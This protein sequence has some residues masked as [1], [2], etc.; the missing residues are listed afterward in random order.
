MATTKYLWDDETDTVVMETDGSGTTQAVYNSD[1]VRYGRLLSMRR[2]GKTYNYR[3]DVPG[4]TRALTDGT[5]QNTDTYSYDAWGNDRATTGATP[6]PYRYNG[7]YGY[8]YTA[9]SDDY[10]IRHRVYEPQIGRWE[11]PGL[12]STSDARLLN[13]PRESYGHYALNAV[14]SDPRSQAV[15]P[16]AAARRPVPQYHQELKRYSHFPCGKYFSEWHFT[17]P[18]APGRTL[19]ISQLCYSCMI[20]D[21][22]RPMKKKTKKTDCCTVVSRRKALSNCFYEVVEN[23]FG[24]GY[25]DINK[26]D[27]VSKVISGKCCTD[28][29]YIWVA[30]NVRLF[31]GALVKQRRDEKQA[32]ERTKRAADTKKWIDGIDDDF[33]FTRCGATVKTAGGRVEQPPF[34][35]DTSLMVAATYRTFRVSW[36]CCTNPATQSF[37][38]WPDNKQMIWKKRSR[39]PSLI[40]VKCRNT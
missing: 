26:N 40:S 11:S 2:G 28:K 29:G 13:A 7:Q 39:F 27:A 9:K 21:C 25:I 24:G 10:Y 3:Y 12:I 36:N 16:A 15:A 5:G 38:A 18:K 37:E 4:N 23:K 19:F 20:F 14:T 34:W 1:P 8:Q 33:K 31:S 6:N 17:F 32:G 35:N 30:N 22:K